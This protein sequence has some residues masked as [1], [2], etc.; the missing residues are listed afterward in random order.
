MCKFS[1]R[2][3]SCFIV[4]CLL[5]VVCGARVFVVATDEELL[6]AANNQ[7]TKLKQICSI[8]GTIYDKDG[9]PLTE[10][11]SSTVSVILPTE[12][13]VIAVAQMLEGDQREQALKTLSSGTPVVVRANYYGFCDSV[14][15]VKAP[16]RYSSIL[17]H[18]IGYCD[19]SGHGVSGLEHYFDDILYSQNGIGIS[20]TTDSNGR[21]IEGMEYEVVEDTPKGSVTLT[22][23]SELQKIAQY[24]LGE[25]Q[26]GTVVVMDA[27]TSEIR[28]IA[29]SPTFD[30]EDISAS[31]NAADSPFLNRAF[32]TYNVGSVF[33]PV[34]AAAAI[35]GGLGDYK[36]TCNGSITV[37]GTTFRCNKSSGHGEVDMETAVAYS[38]NTYF[39]T[40]ALKLG[41]EKLLKTVGGL[42]FQTGL[43]LGGGLYTNKGV[44]PTNESLS[45][46]NTALCNFSIGQ[47][48]LMVTPVNLSLL[49]AAILNGGEYRMPK[50]VKSVEVNG[51][52]TETAQLP[53][54]RAF[55]SATA[56]TLKSYL[57]TALKSG[58]G[59]SAYI[60]GVNAGGKTGTAQTGWKHGD[61]NILNGWFCGFFEGNRTYVITVL[62]EDVQ[63]GSSDCAPIFKSIIS[64]M[65]NLNF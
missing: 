48:D 1:K 28:A 27:E 49:Y 58:T 50:I 14:L 2:A 65:Q 17:T 57:Y 26:S 5:F 45:S 10:A 62:R 30:T 54:T 39:Y 19:A 32:C 56:D 4:L 55:K 25:T 64:Q 46:L 6:E 42:R 36:Y 40:L 52:T 23:D 18:I 29:S 37:N 38:C 20:Y 41:A 8:R 43:D 33:K 63:S 3:L 12:E 47:G 34:I 15:S 53:A 11:L 31:L 21:M 61:R 60:E 24:A 16:K 59:S 22:I 7:S 13:G 51:V 35:E 9:N 44:L